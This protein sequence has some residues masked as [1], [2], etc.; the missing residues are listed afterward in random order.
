LTLD[1]L[2]IELASILAEEEAADV[3]CTKVQF[4][5]EQA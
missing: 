1:E 2:Q 3:D 5:S 4:L